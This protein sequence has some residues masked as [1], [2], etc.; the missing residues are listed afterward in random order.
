MRMM[1]APRD[2]EDEVASEARRRE[3]EEWSPAS[4]GKSVVVREGIEPVEDMEGG[5][6]R[7]RSNSATRGEEG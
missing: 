6:G 4:G 7:R 5:S 1:P 2:W 3:E